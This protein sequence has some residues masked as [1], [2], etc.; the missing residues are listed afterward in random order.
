MSPALLCMLRPAGKDMSAKMSAFR[1]ARATVIVVKRFRSKSSPQ[2]I[3]ENP[4]YEPQ[5]PERMSNLAGLV[6]PKRECSNKNSR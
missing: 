4:R 3:I 6:S 1:C 5:P 2:E